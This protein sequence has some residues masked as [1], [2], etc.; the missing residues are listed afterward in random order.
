MT[1]KVWCDGYCSKNP[2][3]PGGWGVVAEVAFGD[4]SQL[5]GGS[6]KTSSEEMELTAIYQGLNHMLENSNSRTIKVYTDCLMVYLCLTSYRSK[7]KYIRRGLV[8]AALVKKTF[9]LMNKFDD[10]N[11]KHIKGN[12][13]PEHALADNLSY[14]AV[15][16]VNRGEARGTAKS[17]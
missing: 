10:I 17:P 13:C 1:T 11:I 3:G 16:G 5:S 4:R 2:G 12:S 14:K 8:P 7:E 15:W 6:N 9:E